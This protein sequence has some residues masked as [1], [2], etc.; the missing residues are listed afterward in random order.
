MA[1][2]LDRKKTYCHDEPVQKLYHFFEYFFVYSSD[3]D[4]SS[5]M[6]ISGYSSEE[7]DF[8]DIKP[9]P[10]SNVK[11][12]SPIGYDNKKRIKR[13][14]HC[15]LQEKSNFESRNLKYHILNDSP[16][17]R[18]ATKTL[19]YDME[20]IDIDITSPVKVNSSTQKKHMEEKSGEQEEASLTL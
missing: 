6:N 3:V 5:Q 14:R 17:H 8:S 15:L 12:H 10:G 13:K 18:K 7:D 2:S 16:I 1:R 9:L 19:R 11:D 4:R 20:G